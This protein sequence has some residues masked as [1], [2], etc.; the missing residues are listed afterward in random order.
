MSNTLRNFYIKG[1]RMYGDNKYGKFISFIPRYIN[2]ETI[3]DISTN[4]KYFLDNMERY[5]VLNNNTMI[6]LK[7]QRK[8]KNN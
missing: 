3:R 2:D 6:W 5:K 8:L 1:G 7:K 4:T